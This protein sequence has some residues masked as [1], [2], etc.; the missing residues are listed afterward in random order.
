MIIMKTLLVAFLLAIVSLQAAFAAAGDFAAA[1]AKLEQT[2]ARTAAPA[3]DTVELD[4]DVMKTSAAIEELSDYVIAFLAIPRA[5]A[6]PAPSNPAASAFASI[7]LPGTE[8][9]PR[10]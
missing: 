4:T 10:G 7:H 2:Q 3:P 8:P 6:L 9:P 5:I 1:T